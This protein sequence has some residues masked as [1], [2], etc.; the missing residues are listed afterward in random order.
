M[1]NLTYLVTGAN[2]GIGK[3]LAADLL[4]R[5]NTTVIAGVR[6]VAASSSI[7]SALPTGAGSKLIVVK[8]DS[9]IETDA[10]SAV[11]ELTTKHS[12][13]SLDVVIANAGMAH[14]GS[15]VAEVPVSALKEHFNVNTIGPVVLFQAVAPLLK[16]STNAPKFLAITTIIG[17]L[18]SQELMPP[19][20]HFTPYGASKA[21]LNWVIRRV[22]FEN[23]WL[24]AYVSHPGLVK[25][26]L[27]AR[28]IGDETAKAIGAITVAE[29]AAGLL[30]TLDAA[31]RETVGGAF[32]TYDGTALPW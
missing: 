3:G 4:L 11:S 23:E 26:D 16:A 24:T 5:P 28:L 10:A 32:R 19:N 18:A 2:R 14:S 27:T 31:T 8:L 12:I 21:A 1:S 29:S 20:T 6:D 13:T 25:T 22:H 15:P 30:K 7:L 17:S 9:S